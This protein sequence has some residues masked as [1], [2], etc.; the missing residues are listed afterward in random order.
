MKVCIL[1]SGVVGTTAAYYLSR[2]G[3]NVTVIDRQNGP[4]LETSF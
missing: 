3:Y 1:G 4:G 2:T